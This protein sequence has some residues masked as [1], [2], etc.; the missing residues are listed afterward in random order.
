M[1]RKRWTR[2]ELLLA[3]NL[4]CSLPFGKY[5][6]QNHL[7]IGLA[8]LI[9]RTP[10]A[11][12]MKL[13]NF[14]SLDPF[15]RSRGIKGLSHASK[16]DQALWEDFHS[17]WN[18]LVAESENLLIA[19]GQKVIKEKKRSRDKIR[20]M[21]PLQAMLEKFGLDT[22]STR[23]TKARK[24]QQFFRRMILTSYRFRCCI[25][26]NPIPELLIASHILPWR[27]YKRL[28]LEPYNGL[29]LCAI[30]DRAFDA[31]LLSLDSGARLI[32][33]PIISDYLPNK[34]LQSQLLA[35]N[36]KRIEYP[37][38]FAPKEEYFEIHKVRYFCHST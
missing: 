6:R 17:D 15:H 8:E 21:L 12:A 33:S 38:K 18:G 10:S 26:Q 5:H 25:C 36:G 24:G 7:V 28:R 19:L 13:V 23:L 22:E 34:A 11:V 35:F 32:I 1:V 30:H 29:C 37:D 2:K 16:E 31:G 20:K 9:G 27:D 14:A 4:Y 3:F